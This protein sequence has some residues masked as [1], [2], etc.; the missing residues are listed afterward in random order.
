MCMVAQ[1]DD[2]PVFTREW[3]SSDMLS[4]RCALQSAITESRTKLSLPSTALSSSPSQFLA[5]RFFYSLQP[6]NLWVL[7]SSPA[8]PPPDPRPLLDLSVLI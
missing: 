4:L 3:A 6:Q 7:Y 1:T 5:H 8:C 2:W